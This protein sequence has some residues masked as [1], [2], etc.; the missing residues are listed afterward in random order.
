MSIFKRSTVKKVPVVIQM[1]SVECGAASLD[2]IMEYYGKW[3][4]LEEFR[5]A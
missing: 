1:E 3:L 4:P 5:T 2:M